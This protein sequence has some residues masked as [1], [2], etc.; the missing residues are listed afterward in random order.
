MGRAKFPTSGECWPLPWEIL[1]DRTGG[2]GG[3]DGVRVS[4]A[5]PGGSRQWK[6]AGKGRDGRSREGSGERHQDQTGGWQ[7]WREREA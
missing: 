6:G 2:S 3:G 5:A 4:G 7:V 1:P